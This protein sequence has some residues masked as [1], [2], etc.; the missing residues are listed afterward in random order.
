MVAAALL[1]AASALS[2]AGAEPSRAV[3]FKPPGHA[4]SVSLPSVPKH[5]RRATDTAVGDVYTD[6]WSSRDESGNFTVSITDLPSVALWFNSAESL[7]ERSRKEMMASL[8]AKQSGL[9][10]LKRG[11]FQLQVD[12]VVPGRGGTPPRSGRAWFAL[13]DDKLVVL[14]AV[15]Q[16]G[17]TAR[18][19]RHFAQVR[20]GP[21]K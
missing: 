12:Y 17:N 5:N 3:R 9:R 1:V 11:E 15:V 8:K 13:V 10:E 16:N 20:V 18:L 4:F 2:A 7:I 6:V 21:S 19:N 14:T